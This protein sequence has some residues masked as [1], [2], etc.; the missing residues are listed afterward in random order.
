MSRLRFRISMSLDGYVAGPDQSL[1]NPLGVGGMRLHD[2]CCRSRWWRREQGMEGGETNESSRVVEEPTT[3][4]GATHHGAQHVRRVPGEL[5]DGRPVGTAG[6]D[7]T[8]RTTIR[9]SCS[10]TTARAAADGGRH[11]VP[12]RHRRHRVRTGPGAPRGRRSGRDTRGRREGGPAVPEGRP[13]WTRWTSASRPSCW[14]R[15]SGCST[16]WTTLHGLALVRTVAALIVTHLK[17]ARADG[18][19]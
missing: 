10:R 16:A 12:L 5:E 2:G 7:P 6:G 1:A 9:C 11:H 4:I 15:A 3:N 17:L 13:R 14:A 8:R 19:C 18:A